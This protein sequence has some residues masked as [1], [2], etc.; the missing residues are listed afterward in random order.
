M[1]VLPRP[2]TWLIWLAAVFNLTPV[3][4]TFAQPVGSQLLVQQAKD[5]Q[6]FVDSQLATEFLRQTGNLPTADFSPPRFR[7][8]KHRPDLFSSGICRAGGPTET[9]N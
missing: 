2:A 9:G 6:K 7:K 4:Q 1:L 3:D 5:L 8:F